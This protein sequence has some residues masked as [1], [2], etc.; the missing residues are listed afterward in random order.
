MTRPRFDPR[1]ELLTPIPWFS[2]QLAIVERAARTSHGSE[3]SSSYLEQVE[4]LRKLLK[5]GHW[6]VFEHAWFTVL[7]SGVT[8]AFT[9]ELVRHRHLSFTQ[10]STRYIKSANILLPEGVPNKVVELLRD[11]MDRCRELL[12][13]FPRDV[14]RLTYPI[15]IDTS[16]AVSGNLRAWHHLFEI[17]LSPNV[18]EEF[19]VVA[20][21]ILKKVQGPLSPVFDDF[22]FTEDGIKRTGIY[23]PA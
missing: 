13:G 15:G 6:S 4:F 14:I 9:H 23:P 16:I 21:K 7:I 5:A 1:V 17:R 3:M 18:Y 10:S 19:R 12:K 8:R 22:V 11:T 2:T 20:S